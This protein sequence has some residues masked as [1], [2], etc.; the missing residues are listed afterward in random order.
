MASGCRA[1]IL[2]HLVTA[3]SLAVVETVGPGIV[4]Y[5]TEYSRGLREK[6]ELKKARDACQSRGLD[7]LHARL[8]QVGSS[9]ASRW[10]SRP[11]ARPPKPRNGTEV[12]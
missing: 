4:F 9:S 10:T 5:C 3:Q 1:V 6:D 11:G 8:L 12:A 2:D 7:W